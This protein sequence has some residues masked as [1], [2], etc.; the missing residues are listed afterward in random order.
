MRPACSSSAIAAAVSAS[1]VR[2][3]I[4]SQIVQ[5]VHCFRATALL[6]M[7]QL[8]FD[9]LQCGWIQQLAQLCVAQQFTQLPL[10]HRER[11]RSPFRQ[12][13]VAVV[14]VVGDVAEEQRRRER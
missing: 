13:C 6:E 7:L 9:G 12:W 3:S 14:D 1:D 2:A 10:I 8:L 4:S 11:L 5:A